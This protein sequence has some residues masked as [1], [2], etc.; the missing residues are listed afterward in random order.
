M[1]HR[2]H[3]PIF[4]SG[5]LGVLMGGLSYYQR[6]DE[7]LLDYGKPN[8]LPYLWGKGHHTLLDVLAELQHPDVPPLWFVRERLNDQ[9]NQIDRAW[10]DV[11]AGYAELA[12]A[13]GRLPKHG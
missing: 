10:N 7:A 11:S 2:G 6:R 13:A 3:L 5:I 9:I 4:E 1:T 8:S 12:K